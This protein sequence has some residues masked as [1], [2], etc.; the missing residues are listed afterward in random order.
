MH[1]RFGINFPHLGA[2]NLRCHAAFGDI[3]VGANTH[4][5]E[6]T[7]GAGGHRFR[8]VVIDFSR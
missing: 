4:V 8:P 1:A 7:V 2:V 5:Q 3:A 6:F